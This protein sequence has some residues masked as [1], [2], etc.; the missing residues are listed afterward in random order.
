[1]SQKLRKS[2]IVRAVSPLT[3]RNVV[4]LFQ[5]SLEILHL[6]LIQLTYHCEATFGPR[7]FPAVFGRI[8]ET[9]VRFG[10]CSSGKVI[11]TGAASK[12]VTQLSAYLLS[13]YLNELYPG[14]NLLVYNL[15]YPNLVCCCSEG[16]RIDLQALY[17]YTSNHEKH[18]ARYRPLSFQ[19]LTIE[20][21]LTE[22]PLHIVKLIIFSNG[23]INVIGVKDLGDLPLIEAAFTEIFKDVKIKPEALA[24]ARASD[25]IVQT[26]PKGK[27][28]KLE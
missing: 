13:N 22:D 5:L 1:M 20:L 24:T 16:F 27:K 9:G 21:P 6:D 19:G 14:L 17:R 28:R 11:L 25:P 23:N 4:A 26:S 3:V 10:V 8:K 7:E 12:E 2:E 15:Y 18:H